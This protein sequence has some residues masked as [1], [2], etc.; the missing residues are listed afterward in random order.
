M[1][2]NIGT[3]QAKTHLSKLLERVENGEQFTI[4]RHGVPI[5][6]LIPMDRPSTIDFQHFLFALV[7]DIKQLN[8][9]FVVQ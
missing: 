1:M 2:N 5:A 7:F 6:R 9:Y 4:T 8:L 3:Y